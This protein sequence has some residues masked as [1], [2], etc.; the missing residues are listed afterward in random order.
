MR[1]RV[2]VI[3]QAEYLAALGVAIYGF[4]QQLRQP[5]HRVRA[6]GWHLLLDCVILFVVPLLIAVQHFTSYVDLTPSSLE[7]RVLWRHRS[8]HY[9]QIN[10]IVHVSRIIEIYADGMK[11]LSFRLDKPQALLAE[12][13][14]YAPQALREGDPL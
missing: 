11:K 10:R 4:G 1:Y 6:T 12:L 3:N 14:Q 2:H 7:Y 8:I 5:T 13:K 9:G